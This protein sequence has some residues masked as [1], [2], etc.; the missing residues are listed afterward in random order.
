MIRARDNRPPQIPQEIVRRY[1]ADGAI[2]PDFLEESHNLWTRCV[3]A[4]GS[5]PFAL[6]AN[7]YFQ[8]FIKHSVPGYSFPCPDKISQTHVPK[9]T[10]TLERSVNAQLTA[11]GTTSIVIDGSKDG[12]K[13]PIEHIMAHTGKHA[14][15]LKEISTT[16]TRNTSEQV[17]DY[18]QTYR[19]KL[20]ELQVEVLAMLRDNEAT[21]RRAGELFAKSNGIFHV[22]DGAHAIN[23]IFKNLFSNL[24]GDFDEIKICVDDCNKIATRLRNSKDKQYLQAM[25]EI[26]NRMGIPIGALTR[27]STYLKTLKFMHLNREYLKT[28]A[29]GNSEFD[30]T[31][32][33]DIK[34]IIF[35]DNH[36]IMVSSISLRR[37]ATSKMRLTS[38]LLRIEHPDIPATFPRYSDKPLITV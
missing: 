8:D 2:S 36:W 22:G 35:N 18:L 17:A 27:W 21:M 19:N 25:K 9:W 31:M 12:N 32:P 38:P 14:F 4:V 23:L 28:L 30:T 10:K 24:S 13:D 20:D 26:A 33:D 29:R 7:Q 6:I 37:S 16:T 34:N 5:I 11:A 3:T 15:F 1:D